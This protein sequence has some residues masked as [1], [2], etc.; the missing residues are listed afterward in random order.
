MNTEKEPSVAWKGTI[1]SLVVA[2]GR[3][4]LDSKPAY[5]DNK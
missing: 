2:T 4:A 3:V 1:G 5:G